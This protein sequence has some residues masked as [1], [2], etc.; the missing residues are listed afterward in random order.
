MQRK[1]ILSAAPGEGMLC[2]D[3]DGERAGR[4][5]S[6]GMTAED[7]GEDDTLQR[8]RHAGAKHSTYAASGI[9]SVALQPGPPIEN[10]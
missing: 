3:A 9:L 8:A 7:A 4:F 1:S 5:D 2:E 6:L 10:P